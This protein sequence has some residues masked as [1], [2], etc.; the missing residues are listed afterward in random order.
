VQRTVL[1]T[2]VKAA[3]SVGLSPTGVSLEK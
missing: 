3:F 1:T 2:E